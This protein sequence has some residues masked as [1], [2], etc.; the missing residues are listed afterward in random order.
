VRSFR[1]TRRFEDAIDLF[2]AIAAARPEAKADALVARA[3]FLD[4][5]SEVRAAED[6]YAEAARIDP[7]AETLASLGTLRLR[8]EK[9]V[10]ALEAY[11]LALAQAP[12]DVQIR[13]LHAR[14]LWLT[15]SAA[16][17]EREIDGLLAD[18]A[19]FGPAWA[20]KGRLRE[21]AG[22][23]PGA[24]LAFH[25]ALRGDP[26]NVEARFM[27]AR[28][29]LAAK[30]RDQAKRWLAEI[31]DLDARGASGRRGAGELQR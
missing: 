20:V 25:A 4:R 15:G 21:A 29:A 28:R 6:D 26:D 31:W 5:L 23:E 3:G 22:D 9:S 17:A 16:E 24:V 14:A 27:L 13:Y 30:D 11:D 19:A 12:N 10:E 8:M 2:G 1:A 7:R 18:D